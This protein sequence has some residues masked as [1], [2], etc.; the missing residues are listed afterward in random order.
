MHNQRENR[1]PVLDRYT[2]ATPHSIL[3]RSGA[4]KGSRGIGFCDVG[5][6]RRVAQAEVSAL[7]GFRTGTREESRTSQSAV[8]PLAL[9]DLR[10]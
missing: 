5:F 2:N 9:S 1:E 4:N 10:Q 6:L 8:A 3:V 7:C